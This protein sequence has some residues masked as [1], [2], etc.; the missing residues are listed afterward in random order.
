MCILLCW[1]TE[2]QGWRREERVHG[3]KEQLEI[4]CE[5][6][7]EPWLCSCPNGV[8]WLNALC[9]CFDICWKGRGVG[10]SSEP[11]CRLVWLGSID[12]T[13][14]MIEKNH[15]LLVIQSTACAPQDPPNGSIK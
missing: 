1:R 6:L 10:T 4:G 15:S 2:I 13:P 14:E 3:G 9:A 11:G 8:C 12:V 7:E 5:K